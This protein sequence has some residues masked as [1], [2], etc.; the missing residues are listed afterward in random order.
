MSLFYD[1]IKQSIGLKTCLML[2]TL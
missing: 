2:I 1:I